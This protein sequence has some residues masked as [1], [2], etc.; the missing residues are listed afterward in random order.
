MHILGLYNNYY[1]PKMCVTWHKVCMGIAK[2]IL[3][4]K[5]AV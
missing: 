2:H 1:N 5:K 4:E 3:N